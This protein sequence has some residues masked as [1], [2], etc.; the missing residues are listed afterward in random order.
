L[1]PF[2]T[3]RYGR[4]HQNAARTS[5]AVPAHASD[6]GAHEASPNIYRVLEK[7]KAQ[8]VDSPYKLEQIQPLALTSA[9]PLILTV[10]TES[11]Y[12]S[13]K[14]FAADAKA[15]DGQLAFS[16]TGPFTGTHVPLAIFTDADGIE[17]R[18]VPTTGGGPAMTQL[19]AEPPVVGPART[20]RNRAC[21][22]GGEAREGREEAGQELP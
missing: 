9:D 1:T 15:K 18:D 7:N 19:R 12:K 6:G 11:P 21:R 17:M 13:V 2:R 5:S 3:A 4:S 22:G 20:S 10:Q 8:H 16:S 14:D